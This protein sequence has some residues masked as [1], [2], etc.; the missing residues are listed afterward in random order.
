MRQKKGHLWKSSSL[1]AEVTSGSFTKSPTS[2]TLTIDVFLMAYNGWF[3]SYE[4][5]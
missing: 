5:F 2:I 3:H 4:G 1:E